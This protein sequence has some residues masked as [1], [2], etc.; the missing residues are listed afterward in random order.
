MSAKKKVFQTLK[1]SAKTLKEVEESAPTWFY[2][3]TLR[4][5]QDNGGQKQ[6]R[7][8]RRLLLNHSGCIQSPLPQGL[9]GRKETEG[10]ECEKKERCRDDEVRIAR[11]C[12]RNLTRD[13]RRENQPALTHRGRH[14]GDL[15]TE[16]RFVSTY[17]RKV[18]QRHR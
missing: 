2:C 11:R 3:R 14:A 8:L 17:E 10:Q 6:L 16:P 5:R 9:R 12:M 1:T 4:G 13:G 7:L 18:F 15:W